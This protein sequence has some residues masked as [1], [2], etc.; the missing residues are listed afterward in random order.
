[1]NWTSL[2]FPGRT[3]SALIAASDTAALTAVLSGRAGSAPDSRPT[4][5]RID[6]PVPLAGT[7]TAT[8]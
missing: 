1:M 2:V 5:D 8:P 4:L 3:R 6:D 7:P